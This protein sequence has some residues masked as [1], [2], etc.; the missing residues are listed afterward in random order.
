MSPWRKE[1]DL[2]FPCWPVNC[3]KTIL[4]LLVHWFSIILIH[5]ILL[6][7]SV[8]WAKEQTFVY[9]ETTSDMSRDFSWNL[10]EQNQQVVITASHGEDKF[11]NIN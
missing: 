5:F 8:S 9:H 4:F 6:V 7:S 11:F 10:K 3:C 2:R 1:N